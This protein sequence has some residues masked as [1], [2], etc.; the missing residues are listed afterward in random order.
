MGAKSCELNAMRMT[1]M[2]RDANLTTGLIREGGV[3]I[4]KE[5]ITLP[6]LERNTRTYTRTYARTEYE[7]QKQTL[8]LLRLYIHRSMG[9]WQNLQTYTSLDWKCLFAVSYLK[10]ENTHAFAWNVPPWIQ[11]FLYQNSIQNLA[12]RKGVWGTSL[13]TLVSINHAKTS[14]YSIICS[15]LK[16]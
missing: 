4:P 5:D 8:K 1:V 11:S 15:C 3:H 14:T 13:L 12:L 7:K 16:Q 2:G 10:L 6:L 9:R